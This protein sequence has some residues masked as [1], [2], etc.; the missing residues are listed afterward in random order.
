MTRLVR[1]LPLLIWLTVVWV[2]LWGTLDLGTVF[3]G[4][5]AGVVVIAVFPVAPIS[6]NIVV[7]PVRLASLATY[8][9]WDLLIST[10]R[11]AWQALRYRGEAKAG[12]VE[13][14]LRTD[15]D[16][17]TAMVANAVSLAPGKFVMQI[18]R[19][20]R[21]CYVYVLGMSDE[22]AESV[23]REVLELEARVVHA[24]GS[25]EELALIGPLWR[26]LP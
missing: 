6:T 1:R 20:H 12:I 5:L 3:F 26:E 22:D 16:H 9:F 24:V 11:V 13:V 17:L 14:R 18:D 25:R 23:R 7:R 2:M 10:V 4:V 15:S 8:L 19:A 21:L